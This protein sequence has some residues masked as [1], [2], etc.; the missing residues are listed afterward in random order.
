MDPER[1]NKDERRKIEVLEKR[2]DH[3]AERIASNPYKN[4]SYDKAEL[5]ALNWVLN[6][7]KERYW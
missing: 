2:R 6:E 4:L 3:L 7:L 5:G 1:F